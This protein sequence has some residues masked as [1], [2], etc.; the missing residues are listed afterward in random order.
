MSQ[1]RPRLQHGS[2]ETCERGDV[3][4]VR[5]ARTSR[6]HRLVPGRCAFGLL[7]GWLKLVRPERQLSRDLCPIP[8]ATRDPDRSAEGLDT[9]G[10]ADEARRP[11]R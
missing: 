6:D 7:A 1:S 4:E 5:V 10:E 8:R 11:F 2:G 3:D 9:V